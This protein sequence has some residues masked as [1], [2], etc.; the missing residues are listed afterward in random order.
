MF[1]RGITQVRLVVYV[2]AKRSVVAEK[3]REK[4]GGT[5]LMVQ[6]LVG[7]KKKQQLQKLRK[8]TQHLVVR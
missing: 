7:V 8:A 4:I 6:Q 3:V 2:F 5:N 1:A